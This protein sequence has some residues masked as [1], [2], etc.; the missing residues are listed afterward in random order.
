MKFRQSKSHA[1][2]TSWEA[3]ALHPLCLSPGGWVF[4]VFQVSSQSQPTTLLQLFLPPSP[5]THPLP[6]PLSLASLVTRPLTLS[7]TH[8]RTHPFSR[9]SF[10]SPFNYTTQASNTSST[11]R[12]RTF[13]SQDPPVCASLI[14][15]PMPCIH[16]GSQSLREGSLLLHASRVHETP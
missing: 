16:P 13:A 1:I 14:N 15:I 6:P 10:I 9:S 8:S 7:L 5:C 12:E 4:P 11:L 2:Q 3:A